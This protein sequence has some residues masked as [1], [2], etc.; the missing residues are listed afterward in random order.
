ML[1]VCTKPA[2]NIRNDILANCLNCLLTSHVAELAPCGLAAQQVQA[3]P[4]GSMLAD[5]GQIWQTALPAATPPVLCFHWCCLMIGFL[6][7][8][9]SIGHVLPL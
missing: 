6:R 7:V 5:A 1:P 8:A 4:L 2:A 3:M 9:A